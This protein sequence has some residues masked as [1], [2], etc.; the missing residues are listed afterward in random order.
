MPKREIICFVEVEFDYVMLDV[1]RMLPLRVNYARTL[2][3]SF[4]EFYVKIHV[5]MDY[6]CN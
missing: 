5:L 6:A 4:R 2:V 3:G 1:L